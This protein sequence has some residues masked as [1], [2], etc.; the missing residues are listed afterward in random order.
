MELGTETKT[1]TETETETETVELE[2]KLDTVPKSLHVSYLIF[3]YKLKDFNDTLDDGGN[4]RSEFE[5]FA[6]S[7]HNRARDQEQD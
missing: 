7:T 5:L 3:C 6:E 2:L 1:G 4:D